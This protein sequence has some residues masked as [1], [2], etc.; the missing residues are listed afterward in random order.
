MEYARRGRR[1]GPIAAGGFQRHTP[2]TACAGEDATSRHR[3]TGFR[4]DSWNRHQNSVVEL[5]SMSAPISRRSIAVRVS[6]TTPRRVALGQWS[7]L[8]DARRRRNAGIRRRRDLDQPRR[9]HRPDHPSAGTM[10]SMSVPS[11][12]WPWTRAFPLR[13]VNWPS[14]SGGCARRRKAMNY[15]PVTDLLFPNDLM[16]RLR[17]V[18]SRAFGVDPGRST[19]L[20]TRT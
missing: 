3:S 19:S 7:R 17:I 2:D 15:I 12:R 4:P 16:D 6:P 1:G 11:T 20:T 13:T 5:G 8:R 18:A 14:A 9:L 10:E